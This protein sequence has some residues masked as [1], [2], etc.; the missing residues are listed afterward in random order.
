MGE[1][2][3]S[4]IEKQLLMYF[5]NGPLSICS[6]LKSHT[7]SGRLTYSFRISETRKYLPVVSS[8]L[9]L[10]NKLQNNQYYR[11]LVET[12]QKITKNQTGQ[13]QKKDEILLIAFQ[14]AF[15]GTRRYFILTIEQILK[16]NCF[17][18]FLVLHTYIKVKCSFL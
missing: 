16:S 14:R 15:D 9:L 1:G 12:P 8:S 6:P 3:V 7:S 2:G 18:Y 11:V 13:V 17:E 4:K 5:M 10:R